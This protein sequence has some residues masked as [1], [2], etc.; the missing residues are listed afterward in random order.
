MVWGVSGDPACMSSCSEE[1]VGTKSELFLGLRFIVFTKAVSALS[2]TSVVSQITNLFQSVS[3]TSQ[4]PGSWGQLNASR[5][6][7]RGC[8]ILSSTGSRGALML[9]CLSS[10]QIS[11]VINSCS[12][13]PNGCRGEQLC[14]CCALSP[15]SCITLCTAPHPKGVGSTH[16]W[17][18]RCTEKLPWGKECMQLPSYLQNTE[19]GKLSCLELVSG[20]VNLGTSS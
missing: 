13:E 14:R 19:L 1:A 9:Q 18:S 6:L 3:S 16:T 15:L 7:L 20:S 8:E 12:E 11:S 5:S 4:L 10:L 2:H 17:D